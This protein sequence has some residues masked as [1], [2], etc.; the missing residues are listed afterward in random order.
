MGFISFPLFR[1]ETKKESGSLYGLMYDPPPVRKKRIDLPGP[2]Y[3]L[4][5]VALC[6]VGAIGYFVLSLTK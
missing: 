4:T 3:D 2:F 5:V 6:I 1:M